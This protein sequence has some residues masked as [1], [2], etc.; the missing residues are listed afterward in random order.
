MS[1]K[2]SFTLVE[3]L[4]V[5]TISGILIVGTVVGVNTLW[6]NNRVDICESEMREFSN[7][8]KSYFTDYGSITIAD[9]GNYENVINAVV[10]L[11]NSK[12]LSCDIEVTNIADDKKSVTLKTKIKEDPWG[13]KYELYIYTY[14]GADSTSMSGLVIVSSRG[15]DS[16]SN[17]SEYKDGNYGDDV[18]TVIKPN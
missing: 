17:K 8:F 18:I 6:Q 4:A 12:Y 14:S 1:K 15:R 16:I 7:A 2:R 9:D 5:L 3:I 11:L 10:E 13:N